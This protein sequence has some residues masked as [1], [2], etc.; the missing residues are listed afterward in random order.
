[1]T[2]V[3]S[4][5][6]NED[7]LQIF[8]ATKRGIGSSTRII[9]ELDLSQKQYYTR[10]NQ[11]LKAGL[12]EKTGGIYRHTMFGSAC[13]RLGENFRKIL[14]QRERFDLM[15]RL[16]NVKAFSP[17]EKKKVAQSLSIDETLDISNLTNPVNI[18]D[19]YKNLIQKTGKLIEKAEH[20]VYF[21]TQYF[22]MHVVEAL[23]NGM[24]RGIQFNFLY[25]FQNSIYGRLG[26]VMKFLFSAPK[27]L[28]F[29]YECLK[30]KNIQIQ[31]IELPYS[32]L[33]IDDK[34]SLFE[35]KNSEGDFFLAF[36][37]E[38]TGLCQKLIE[39]FNKLWEK[40]SPIDLKDSLVKSLWNKDDKNHIDV[41][42][43][44]FRKND[45]KKES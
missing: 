20:T 43:K 36:T 30:S 23:I 9:R 10:L 13:Y 16:R 17:N 44:I 39:N 4:T 29:F 41:D 40:S 25:D 21:A 42:P 15:D 19:N 28:N 27:T 14:G 26:L 1:M 12:I 18:I 35:I 31:L 8:Y 5:L 3:L 2:Q 37:F 24:Q 38:N 32:F 45:L 34:Y 7:A 33:V 6:G 22:D 11:L